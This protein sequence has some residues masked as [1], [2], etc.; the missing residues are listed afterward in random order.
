MIRTLASRLPPCPGVLLRSA[1]TSERKRISRRGT[2]NDAEEARHQ[3]A[4]SRPRWRG[5]RERDGVGRKRLG[6]GTALG[7]VLFWG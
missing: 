5:C 4:A 6:F 3:P 2:C 1:G 7:I